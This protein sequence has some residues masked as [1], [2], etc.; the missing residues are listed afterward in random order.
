MESGVG[1]AA[2]FPR[3][4]LRVGLVLG[5]ATLVVACTAPAPS[6][7]ATQA[8]IIP[9]PSGWSLYVADVDGPPIVI[10]IDG[11]VVARVPCSG[12]TQ[13]QAG[14]HGVPPLPW[15]LDVRR[16]DGG[17]L[18]HFDVSGGDNFT[19]LL[20]GDTVALGQFGSAGPTT[21]PDACA[22]W[23]A[24]PG[25]SATAAPTQWWPTG[26]SFCVTPG[27]YLVDGLVRAFGDCAGLLLDPPA[28]VTL[29]SGQ[30]VDVHVRT[31]EPVASQPSSVLPALPAS[32]NVGVL[33]LVGVRDGGGTATYRAE[34]VGT[35]TCRAVTACTPRPWRR[36]R[37]P[38][39]C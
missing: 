1:I 12:Y 32:S 25:P 16:E 31:E 18:H 11:T 2:R 13:L 33:R 5:G 19:L 35:A 10:L 37:G 7:L 15:S 9:A 28:S 27:F 30:Q 6:P 34:Q 20:R 4:V 22:R 14:A 38:V 3:V 8:P 26:L 29:R 39:P 36:P 17:L 23:T 21:A 24:S